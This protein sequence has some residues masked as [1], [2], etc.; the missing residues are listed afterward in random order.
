MFTRTRRLLTQGSALAL[1]A[2]VAVSTSGYVRHDAT[3]GSNARARTA[4]AVVSSARC[5]RPTAFLKLSS[6]DP[7]MI[8]GWG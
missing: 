6:V 2:A 8:H 3:A 5:D 1:A 4:A 7:N